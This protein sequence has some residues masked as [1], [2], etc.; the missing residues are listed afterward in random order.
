VE[1]AEG[2]GKV[3][4]V[5]QE[6]LTIAWPGGLEHHCCSV[7]GEGIGKRSL[8]QLGDVVAVCVFV[9]DPRFFVNCSLPLLR[10]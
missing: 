2:G 8:D 9:N 3:L 5:I 1:E 10:P 4:G 6:N 7:R